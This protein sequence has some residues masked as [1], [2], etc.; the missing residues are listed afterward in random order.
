[1]KT[2]NIELFDALK[3]LE[4]STPL[5]EAIKSVF[6]EGKPLNCTVGLKFKPAVDKVGVPFTLLKFI[7]PAT[8]LFQ[9]VTVVPEV[10]TLPFA[11]YQAFKLELTPPGDWAFAII[12]LKASEILNKYRI[13]N[14]F[15]SIV[16]ILISVCMWFCKDMK[17]IFK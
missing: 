17:L 12:K 14:T 1:M 4:P 6:G 7:P 3:K 11:F 2:I 8:W 9:L 13:D 15:C 16:F 5:F 10:V